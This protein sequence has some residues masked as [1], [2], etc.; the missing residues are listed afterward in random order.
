MDDISVYKARLRMGE[1]LSSKILK[2]RPDLLEPLYRGEHALEP[3]RDGQGSLVLAS[4]R[5]G[6]RA[7]AW[8]GGGVS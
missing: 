8:T 7:R 5:D 1:A 3:E 2:T 4:F 6:C